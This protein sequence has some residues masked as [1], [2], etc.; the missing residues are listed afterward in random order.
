MVFLLLL[1]CINNEREF[2]TSIENKILNKHKIQ[3]MQYYTR[4]KIYGLIKYDY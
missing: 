4:N 2:K 3:Y 1:K